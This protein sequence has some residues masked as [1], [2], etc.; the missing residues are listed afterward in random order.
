[1]AKLTWWS[2]TFGL[3]DDSGF[4]F[5][6]ERW[7]L[8]KDWKCNA[9][10]AE[11]YLNKKKNGWEVSG[12]SVEFTPISDRSITLKCSF[13]YWTF[14]LHPSSRQALWCGD[15]PPGI[16]AQTQPFDLC[17][18]TVYFHF[19]KRLGTKKRNKNKRNGN[20]PEPSEILGTKKLFPLSL[21]P[22]SDRS[23]T[24]STII[25]EALILILICKIDC[26]E[27]DS[28]PAT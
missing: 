6:V 21:L 7:N 4:W 8:S 27:R 18:E 9:L 22:L 3:E 1:M 16:G 13:F 17:Q 5:S 28:K 14:I 12:R 15:L 24:P 26:L 19:W 25:H 10:A 23:N 11:S 2:E 20:V